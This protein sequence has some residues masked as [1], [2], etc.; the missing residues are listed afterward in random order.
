[1]KKLLGISLSRLSKTCDN[2]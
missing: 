1:M 2:L